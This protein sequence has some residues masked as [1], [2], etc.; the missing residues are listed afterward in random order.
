MHI[1]SQRCFINCR[2]ILKTFLMFCEWNFAR[3]NSLLISRPSRPT[4]RSTNREDWNRF[5][6]HLLTTLSPQT[7]HFSRP[8]HI[9]YEIC[10]RE[11]RRPPEVSASGHLSRPHKTKRCKTANA[12]RDKGNLA[13]SAV[14]ILDGER[15]KQMSNFWQA[16]VDVWSSVDE[17]PTMRWIGKIVTS[18]ADVIYPAI[19]EWILGG[20]TGIALTG[21][22]PGRTG[23]DL[24]LCRFGDLYMLPSYRLLVYIEICQ[25]FWL[26]LYATTPYQ[27]D[28]LSFTSYLLFIILLLF[29]CR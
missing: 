14:F 21:R 28:L 13:V 29:I 20:L 3:S 27:Q 25:I 12:L 19:S 18:W 15:A 8:R 22:V 5:I 9:S 17:L 16:N 26:Y 7:A 23:P 24:T 1:F 4:I 10:P 2:R 6:R 11:T